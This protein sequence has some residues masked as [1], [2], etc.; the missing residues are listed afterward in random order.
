M[1]ESFRY[2]IRINDAKTEWYQV[3]AVPRPSIANLELEEEYPQYIKMKMQRRNTSDLTLLNGSRL[4]VRLTCNKPLAQATARLDGPDQRLPMRISGTVATIT[5]D[6]LDFSQ[7]EGFLRQNRWSDQQIESVRTSENWEQTLRKH[8]YSEQ[9]LAT[10]RKF[11]H[12][13]EKPLTGISF[14]LVDRDNVASTGETVFRIELKDDMPPEVRI[15]YPERREEL[16]T[17]QAQVLLGF[18]AKDD[19]ALARLALRW[20]LDNQDDAAAQAIEM[21]LKNEPDLKNVTR[22]FLFELSKLPRLVPEGSTV[23]YWVEAEDGNNLTGPGR[24]ASERYKV[25][26]VSKLEKLTDLWGRITDQFGNV[27]SMTNTQ[28]KLTESLGGLI[29]PK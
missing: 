23:E 18:Q 26:I 2:R 29:K 5:V 15:T 4:R 25:K 11:I 16:A 24:A 27:E 3:K 8:N 12:K 13:R 17:Q 19:Y 22:A 20:K 14:S 28:E 9:I 21:D 1:Q 6:T 10:L 7:W